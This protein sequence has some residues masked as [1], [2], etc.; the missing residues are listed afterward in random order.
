MKTSLIFLIIFG[1]FL[2]GSVLGIVFDKR[3]FGT[4]PEKII[5]LKDL[6]TIP[7]MIF[8]I[9]TGLSAGAYLVSFLDP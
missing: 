3:V 9:C 4:T 2:I 1:V 7:A 5:K 6:W 8:A